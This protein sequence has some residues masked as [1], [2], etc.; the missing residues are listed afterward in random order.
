MPQNGAVKWVLVQLGFEGANREWF[1][2]ARLTV[3]VQRE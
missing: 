1:R 2:Y 3:P